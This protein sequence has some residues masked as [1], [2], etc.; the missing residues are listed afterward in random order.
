MIGTISG[1]VISANAAV[2]STQPQ[3]LK[4]PKPDIETETRELDNAASPKNNFHNDQ[5]DSLTTINK[6]PALTA[7]SETSAE[8]LT[9]NS[10]F[11]HRPE[12]VTNSTHKTTDSG[13]TDSVIVNSHYTGISYTQ[14][15]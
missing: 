3:Q 13:L 15:E 11:E 4:Q 14:S 9:N 12:R 10:G 5:N 8:T 1:S 2:T 7:P 6:P